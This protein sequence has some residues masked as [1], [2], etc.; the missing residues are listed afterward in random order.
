MSQRAADPWPETTVAIA[1]NVILSQYKYVVSTSGSVE[2]LQLLNVTREDAAVV[3]CNGVNTFRKRAQLVIL[4]EYSAF[5]L[6]D[7]GLI[8]GQL[9]M[10]WGPFYGKGAV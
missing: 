3:E 9:T 10:D 2:T 4:G 6:L 7:M 5:Y 8:W 1:G